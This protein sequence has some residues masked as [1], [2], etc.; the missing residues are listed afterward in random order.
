LSAYKSCLRDADADIAFVLDLLDPARDEASRV[1]IRQSSKFVLRFKEEKMSDKQDNKS[2]WTTVPGLLTGCAT[3]LTAIGG[4]VAALYAAGLLQ[5]WFPVATPVPPTATLVRLSNA[6]VPLTATFTRPADTA[7]PPIITPAGPPNTT[8]P[9][10]VPPTST[11]NT[12]VPPT[13][14]FTPIPL[15]IAGTRVRPPAT[16]SHT[17]VPQARFIVN[18][19][20]GRCIDVKGKPGVANESPLQLWDCEFSNPSTDQ[21]WEFT[22]S[23]FIRNTLSGKCIDVKGK[24][25]VANGSPLQLWD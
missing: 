25:A 18:L 2:F 20:S 15:E 10:T 14:T 21:K 12:P 22:S 11:S 16:S 8:V 1:W 6:V 5:V 3:I 17:P 23:G 4:L 19:L 9:P 24:P 13:S 7:V